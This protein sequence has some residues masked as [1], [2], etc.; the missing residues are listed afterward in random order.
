[1]YRLTRKGTLVT[2]TRRE[3]EMRIQLYLTHEE[4]QVVRQGVTLLLNSRELEFG[5]VNIQALKSLIDKFVQD[6]KKT[7]ETE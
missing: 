3:D 7:G 5:M 6:L 2:L 4:F 1:M